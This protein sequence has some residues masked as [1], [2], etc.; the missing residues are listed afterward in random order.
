MLVVVIE[1]SRSIAWCHWSTAVIR[2]CHF[3]IVYS[4]IH[5]NKYVWRPLS[6]INSLNMPVHQLN[7]QPFGAEW[8]TSHWQIIVY[9][10]ITDSIPNLSITQENVMPLNKMAN[11]YIMVSRNLEKAYFLIPKSPEDQECPDS[12][13]NS[14]IT[15]ALCLGAHKHG[16]LRIAPY[17]QTR[18][19][20]LFV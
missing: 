16:R 19:L 9:V 3:G 1:V 6:N 2:K 4:S 15:A 17:S 13:Q 7:V 5:F 11:Q 12:R 8:F 20:M 10:R 14:I 18:S